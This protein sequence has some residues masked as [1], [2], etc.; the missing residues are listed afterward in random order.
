MSIAGGLHLAIGR[1]AEVGCDCL[2][3]FVK[4]QRQWR[5]PPL[6]D[7]DLR[8]WQKALDETGISPVVAHAT[9]L[10]NLASPDGPLWRRS[11][12]TYVGE[13]RRCEKLGLIGLVIHPGSHMGKGDTWGLRRIAKALDR[14]HERTPGFA[15]HTILET[16]AGQGTC[17]GHRFGHLA[18]IIS[19][20][21]EPGRVRICVDTCHIFAAGYDLTTDESYEKTLDELAGT[22]GLDRVAVF[23]LNDS[24]KPLGSR[25][26]RHGEIGKHAL[27]RGAFGRLV[28]DTRFLGRPMILETPKGTDPRGRDLDRLNLAALR[29]LIPK[30]KIKPAG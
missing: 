9:Y 10:I 26:D 1:A 27:G 21:R 23:H 30:E 5:A 28:N 2:Q 11:I 4:N 19:R 20:T 7:A 24:L 16:T 13:L 15:T 25:R 6:T 29:R 8:S 12:S 22:V 14:I 17:L 3:I 18:D